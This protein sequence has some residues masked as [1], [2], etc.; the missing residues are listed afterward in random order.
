MEKSV[1]ET[2]SLANE[3]NAASDV[4]DAIVIGGGPAGAVAARQLSLSGARVL[5]VERKPFPRRKVCGACLNASGLAV[6]EAIGLREKVLA[7]HG[8]PLQRFHVR[9]GA[10]EF[11]LP[12]PEGVAISRA[13]LDEAL[14]GWAI[15]S[16]VTF[17]SRTRAVVGPARDDERGVSLHIE[18]EATH[19]TIEVA[20]RVVLAADGLGHPSL[21]DLPEF[22]SH[23]TDGSRIGAGC[24]VRD[25]PADYQ[26][27][28]IH[29]AVGRAGYVGLAVIE[30]GALNVAAALD[31]RAVREH[32]GLAAAAAAV[33]RETGCPPTPS[34]ADADWL[35]TP[36]LTRRESRL[37]APRLFLVGDAAGYIE[38]FTGE[39]MT[40]AVHAGCAV[41]P[42][43]L[44]AIHDWRPSLMR[45]WTAL[46]QRLVGRRQRV[47][48]VV[49]GVLRRPWLFAAATRLLSIAP[50][51]VRPLVR[52]IHTP[53]RLSGLNSPSDHLLNA[54]INRITHINLNPALARP[55]TERV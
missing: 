51:V 19:S 28:T 10:G 48:R 34:L 54:R 27:G 13:A 39:G 18:G 45:D 12:L 35:G 20:A 52:F 11:M 23:A 37:A 43:A 15:D 26:A 6:L 50:R 42:L 7:L 2:R 30:T 16:G 9:G 29:M 1:T 8:V 24:E 36:M 22:T 46:H 31:A 40:W 53:P 55:T 17:Q 21:C 44:R 32:G 38:P 41:T 47:C 33:L 5:L 4:W 14:V 49:S 25:F 3:S